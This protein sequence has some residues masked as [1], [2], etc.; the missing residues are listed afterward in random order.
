MLHRFGQRVRELRKAKGLSQEAFA[1]ACGLDRTY[2]S[3]IERG[4]RNVA[5]VNIAQIAR[6]L[7]VTISELTEGL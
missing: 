6:T 3:G 4:L 5:L 2:I 1:D 7:D